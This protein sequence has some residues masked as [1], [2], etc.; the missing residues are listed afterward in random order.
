MRS[1]EISFVTPRTIRVAGKFVRMSVGAFLGFLHDHLS[2]LR[3]KFSSWAK[4]SH[5]KKNPESIAG[6]WWI[7]LI[8][9]R[10]TRN[11]QPSTVFADIAWL[12]CIIYVWYS[13]RVP[14]NLELL[15]F[16]NW[17][18]GVLI[19][20]FL[21]LS[22]KFEYSGCIK[23]FSRHFTFVEFQLLFAKYNNKRLCNFQETSRF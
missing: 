4:F 16:F 15:S 19:D 17:S 13:D 9:K 21:H 12:L 3:F 20:I 18:S 14:G 1:Y 8:N 22:Y 6:F 23:T 11:R 7:N 10:F 5:Q 2:F